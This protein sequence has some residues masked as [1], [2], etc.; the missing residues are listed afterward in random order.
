LGRIVAECETIVTDSYGR[1]PIITR[2]WFAT[3]PKRSVRRAARTPSQ[4]LS[5]EAALVA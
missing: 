2:A 1:R 5:A 3:N 4:S